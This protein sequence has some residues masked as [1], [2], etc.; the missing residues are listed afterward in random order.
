MKED[1]ALPSQPPESVE[2][3]MSLMEKLL[4]RYDPEDPRQFRIPLDKQIKNQPEADKP[5]LLHVVKGVT[6][7]GTPFRIGDS[8]AFDMVE[9]FR[10]EIYELGDADKPKLTQ[11]QQ[12]F[13]TIRYALRRDEAGLWNVDATIVSHSVP[14]AI[15]RPFFKGRVTWFAG[16]VE[17]TGLATDVVPAADGKFIPIVAALSIHLTRQGD[18]LSVTDRWQNYG[19]ATGPKGEILLAPNFAKPLGDA[20]HWLE[21]KADAS[22]G[23]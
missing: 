18:I 11:K 9:D 16:G 5:A 22:R 21:G 8:I 7:V 12:R 3:A 15:G 20:Y 6:I 19:V 23:G 1:K 10:R 13:S 14:V 4:G 17:L 2:D